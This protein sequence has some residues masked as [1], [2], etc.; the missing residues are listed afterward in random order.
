MTFPPT[1]GG[2]IETC[3]LPNARRARSRAVVSHLIV[4]PLALML[5]CCLV[6][7]STSSD[8][9]LFCLMWQLPTDF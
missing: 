9:L 2:K 4:P 1:V 5:L 6:F 3:L 7:P 8:F